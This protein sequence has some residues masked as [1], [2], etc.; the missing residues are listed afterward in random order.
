E[1]GRE[2]FLRLAETTDVVIESSPPGAW[3]TLGIGWETLHRRNP[4]LILVSITP[5]GQTGPYRDYAGGDLI[6]QAMGGLMYING[7]PEDPPVRAGGRQA[8]YSS[9][10]HACAAALMALYGRDF[11]SP[12]EGQWIDVSM[13]ESVAAAVQPDINFWD[14]RGEVKKREGNFIRGA[15]S[16]VFKTKDGYLALH[17]G[18]RNWADLAD[19]LAMD[20]ADTSFMLDPV[21]DEPQTRIL[22]RSEVDSLIEQLCANRTMD[23]LADEGQRRGLFTFPVFN[24]EQVAHDKQMAARHWFIDLPAPGGQGTLRYPGPPV[25]LHATPYVIRRPA[26]RLGEHNAEVY[27]SLGVAPEDLP[28]LRKAMAI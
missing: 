17:S 16:G 10:I 26:P 21:W 27:G 7:Y 28:D 2:L 9:G 18:L 22:R 4:R 1:R 15:G 5:F 12:G 13:Q 6:A 25:R 11:T 23:E 3:E 19:W 14:L 24:A 20:G 8:E